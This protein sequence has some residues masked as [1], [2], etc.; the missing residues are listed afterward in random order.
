VKTIKKPRED[1]AAFYQAYTDSRLRFGE[2]LGRRLAAYRDAQSWQGAAVLDVGCG[3]GSVAQAFAGCGAQVTA[4]ERS[5]NRV[6]SMGRRLASQTGRP[7]FRLLAGDGHELPFANE[8]FDLII[9]SDVI[10][11]VKNP[12]RVLQEAARVLRPGGIVYAS[13]PSRYSILNLVSDPHYQVPGVGLMPRWM[14][15]WYVVRLLRLT[16][17]YR[18]ERYFTWG[19]VVELFRRVGLECQELKGRYER[20]IE[21]G[22]MPA[23]RSRRWMAKLLYLPGMR[24]LALRLARTRLFRYC[25][26]PGWEFLAFKPASA[27]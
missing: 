9:L 19:E 15:A 24:R 8:K 1:L 27:G 25:I 11:H 22:E 16:D 3:D 5:L 2:E 23:A 6:A 17:G 12:L 7:R 10:E 26:Q 13:M 20:K 14:A 21:T 4:L 18:T